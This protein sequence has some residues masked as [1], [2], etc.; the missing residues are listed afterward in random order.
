[1][2]DLER[3]TLLAKEKQDEAARELERQQREEETRQKKLAENIQK[4]F[5]RM[6]DFSS[7]LKEKIPVTVTS[8]NDHV[9]VSFHFYPEFLSRPAGIVEI[10]PNYYGA[11]EFSVR[12]KSP[13]HEIDERNISLEEAISEVTKFCADILTKEGSKEWALPTW[14]LNAGIAIGWIGGAGIWFLLCFTGISGI[15]LGWIPAW[16]GR[17]LLKFFWLPAG[18]FLL[19]VVK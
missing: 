5:A 1:M 18:I 12:C 3:V 17:A 4:I 6:N 15:L 2:S 13:E 10:H 14:Y 16:I 8:H 9:R 7:S 19:Y 11:D